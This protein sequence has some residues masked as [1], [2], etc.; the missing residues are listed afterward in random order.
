[1]VAGLSGSAL[2]V[3]TMMSFSSSLARR[4][5]NL[6]T[7]RTDIGRTIELRAT[8][9]RGDGC[10]RMATCNRGSYSCLVS[11]RRLWNVRLISRHTDFL[12][13]YREGSRGDFGTEL[14]HLLQT[15]G[16]TLPMACN[17]PDA[18]VPLLLAPSYVTTAT[19]R[20]AAQ[21]KAAPGKTAPDV[22]LLRELP[23]F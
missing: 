23:G 12:A 5:R 3:R 1:M 10:R 19:T 9:R 6:A 20:A 4:G 2:S 7:T 15:R 22:R 21:R 18:E 8:R 14:L 17:A 11:T 16:S 13:C